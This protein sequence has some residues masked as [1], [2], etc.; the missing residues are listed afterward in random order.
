MEK[1]V[2]VNNF[3]KRR[4]FEGNAEFT[5]CTLSQEELIRALGDGTWSTT[6][7]GDVYSVSLSPD[8]VERFLT[9]VTRLREGDV[10]VGKYEAR[11]AGEEPRKHVRVLK[12]DFRDIYDLGQIDTGNLAAQ[13]VTVI[14][15]SSELLARDGED[16]VLPAEPGNYEVISI[17][18]SPYSGGEPIHPNTLMANYFGT[19]GGSNHGETMEQFVAKLKASY[20]FWSCHALAATNKEE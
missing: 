6:N 13:S 20:E 9:P 7:G 8:I 15:Y 11:K 12:S 19:S 5:V 14:L 1:I 4:H 17:N 3:A 2:A 10:L 18:A 16:H